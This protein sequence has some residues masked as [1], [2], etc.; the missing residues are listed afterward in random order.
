M[1]SIVNYLAE[2]MTFSAFWRLPM[3]YSTKNPIVSSDKIRVI[4]LGPAGEGTTYLYG[5]VL[6]ELSYYAGQK[7]AFGLLVGHA[8]RKWINHLPKMRRIPKQWITR[9]SNRH[10][11]RNILLA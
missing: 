7:D 9:F 3:T 5:D 10:F 11:L 1:Q 6:E 4:H 2:N 8:Y